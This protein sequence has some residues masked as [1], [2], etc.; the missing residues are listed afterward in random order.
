MISYIAFVMHVL[1][2]FSPAVYVST[3]P[4]TEVAI[5]IP[6]CT[7]TVLNTREPTLKLKFVYAVM[8]FY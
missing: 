1:H 5:A 6:S 4:P 3:E 2:Y 8:G 7:G